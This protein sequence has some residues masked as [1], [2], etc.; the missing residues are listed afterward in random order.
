MVALRSLV[1]VRCNACRRT[2]NYRPEDLIEIFGDVDA[3]SLATRMKC[4]RNA[5]HGPLDV[6]SFLPEGEYAVGLRIR[7]LV[8]L[9]LVRVPVW[10][11]D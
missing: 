4:E 10:R 9:K 8:A 2:D 7:R 1:R 5:G 11:D 3:N 6:E